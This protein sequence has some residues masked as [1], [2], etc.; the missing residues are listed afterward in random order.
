MSDIKIPEEFEG[1][2][3]MGSGPKDYRLDGLEDRD[4]HPWKFG[5]R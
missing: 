2:I 5:V 4:A 1:L 3:G